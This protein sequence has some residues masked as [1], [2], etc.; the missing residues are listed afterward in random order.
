MGFDLYA[1][2][3]VAVKQLRDGDYETLFKTDSSYFRNN[4]WWWR[5]LWEFTSKHCADILSEEDIERGHSNE[6]HCITDK[7]AK[8][9]AARLTE[10]I[11]DGT[12][13]AYETDVKKYIEE[14]EKK[15]KKAKAAFLKKHQC[16]TEDEFRKLAESTLNSE[17]RHKLWE[18]Y[19][20]TTRWGAA[21][22]FSV[23][24]LRNFATFC[25]ASMGFEIC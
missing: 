13:A 16:T 21:Y 22:P 2:N 18:S 12:A 17:E 14:E 9:I 5:R 15:E 4:V 11:K 7:K 3:P 25:D 10:L 20:E 6:C 24:N 8:A 23:E 19:H 1:L